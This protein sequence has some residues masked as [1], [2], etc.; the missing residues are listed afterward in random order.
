MNIT[1][2]I[3]KARECLRKVHEEYSTNLR[4]LH[5]DYEKKFFEITEKIDKYLAT[6]ENNE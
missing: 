2:D 3:H 4:N 1:K 5:I 6:L